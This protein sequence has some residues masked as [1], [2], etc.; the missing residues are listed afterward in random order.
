MIRR[1]KKLPFQGISR[2][3]HGIQWNQITCHRFAASRLNAVM[4][5]IESEV[6]C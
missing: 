2:Q 1:A 6:N 4:D 3:I 5:F